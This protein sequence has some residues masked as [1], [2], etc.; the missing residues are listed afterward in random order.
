MPKENK[1]GICNIAHCM[2]K[3]SFLFLL[4]L[5]FFLPSIGHAANPSFLITSHS[6]SVPSV[7]D[8]VTFQFS[9]MDADGNLQKIEIYVNN[10]IEKTC[11]FVNVPFGECNVVKAKGS[12]AA[13]ATVEYYGKAYDATS[14]TIS[15]TKSFAISGGPLVAPDKIYPGGNDIFASSPTF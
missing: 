14:S 12:F 13:G 10:T 11:T 5:L 9:A 6:P 7:S 15:S 2:R 4:A 1:M 8:D 3:L